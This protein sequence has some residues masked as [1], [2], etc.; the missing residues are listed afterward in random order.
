MASL[1]EELNSKVVSADH[2]CMAWLESRTD[3]ELAAYSGIVEIAHGIISEAFSSR[4]ILPG[5]TTNTDV[6]FY[7]MQ[8]VIDLKLSPWFDFETS[9]I[10]EHEGAIGKETIIMPGDI[11]HCDVGLK[12]LGLCTDTQ[13]NAYVLK[14]HETEAPKGIME[15]QKT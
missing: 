4:V 1:S 12:Y 8:R 9:V 14:V 7:M 13:H 5:V 15:L 2:L 11:L 3:S 6:K 10:R